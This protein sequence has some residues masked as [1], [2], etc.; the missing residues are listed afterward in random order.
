MKKI[1]ENYLDFLN[2]ENKVE[3]LQE[4]FIIF[5]LSWV[6]G[7]LKLLYR[8]IAITYDK[9]VRHCGVFSKGI[10]RKVCMIVCRIDYAD[11]KIKFYK[12][13]IQ[14]CKTKEEQK[15]KLKAL[16]EI[17]KLK[18]YILKKEN[19]LEKLGYRYKH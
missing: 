19:Q 18:L 15:Y 5:P 9:C 10:E 12:H 8:S 17:Q 14:K 11:Q 3:N 6:T 2:T 13:G 4:F 1:T 7:P 16:K